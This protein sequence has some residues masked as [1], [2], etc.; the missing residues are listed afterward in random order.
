MRK[1]KPVTICLLIAA[2]SFAFAGTGINLSFLGWFGGFALLLGA[3]AFR[4]R[5]AR[6]T[7]KDT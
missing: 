4:L 3:L 2:A 6:D 1:D 7:R 5:S